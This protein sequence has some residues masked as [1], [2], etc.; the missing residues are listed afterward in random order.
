M[1]KLLKTAVCFVIICFAL[2]TILV[3]QNVKCLLVYVHPMNTTS[4]YP[5]S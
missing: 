2:Q 4:L 3:P 1:F 5:P